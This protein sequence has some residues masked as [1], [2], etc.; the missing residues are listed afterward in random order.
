MRFLKKLFSGFRSSQ[1]NTV[2]SSVGGAA[3]DARLLLLGKFLKCQ[4]VKAL[5]ANE[6]ALSRWTAALG[7]P[8][9]LTVKE[10]V[11]E[12]LLTSPTLTER[13]ESGKSLQK[14]KD[15]CREYGLKQTGKKRELA[16]RVIAHG[17]LEGTVPLADGYICSTAGREVA[18]AY[19]Q[20]KVAEKLEAHLRTA[21]FLDAH[22][23]AG[24]V[25]VVCDYEVRQPFQRGMGVNWSTGTE[26]IEYVRSIYS[27]Q[28][29]F[30]R[31]VLADDLEN[32]RLM[33]ALDNLWGEEVEIFPD[34]TAAVLGCKYNIG[35]AARQLQ[36]HHSHSAGGS[37]RGGSS[38]SALIEYI[39]A[40]GDCAACLA[41]DGKRYR[42]D[43]TPELPSDDCTCELGCRCTFGFVFTDLD[44]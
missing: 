16:E 33:A 37:A 6:M 35:I 11:A 2:S 19:K 34:R 27:A 43:R 15:L 13:L 14:L 21:D 38:K 30:L 44:G 36:F 26:G 41:R 23:F 20:R 12:G 10:L 9:A 31:N 3:Q 29:A 7:R 22:D 28:K 42:L 17:I 4:S 5:T 18:E 32:I 25:K 40:Q 39:A 24:A 1:A 8:P